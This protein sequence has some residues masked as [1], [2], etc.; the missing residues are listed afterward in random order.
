MIQ[1]TNMEVSVKHKPGT[2]AF[3]CFQI[4]FK[5][6]TPCNAEL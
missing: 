6:Y 3:F 2:N 1:E 4:S 5:S